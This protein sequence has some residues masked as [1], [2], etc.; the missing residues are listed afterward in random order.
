MEEKDV[1]ARKH[2]LLYQANLMQDALELNWSTAKRGHAAALIEIEQGNTSQE[3]QL[4]VDKIHEK[5]HP[6]CPKNLI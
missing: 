3:D 6:E 2:M 5:I 4:T 1:Q